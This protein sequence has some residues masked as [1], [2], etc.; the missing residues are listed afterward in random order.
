MGG[1]KGDRSGMGG[2]RDNVLSKRSV[3]QWGMGNWQ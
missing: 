3:K 1:K 2:V